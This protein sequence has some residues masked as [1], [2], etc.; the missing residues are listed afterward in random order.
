[1]DAQST[2][3]SITGDQ[4]LQRPPH[5]RDPIRTD[6]DLDSSLDVSGG[7]ADHLGIAESLGG[8]PDSRVDGIDGSKFEPVLDGSSSTSTTTT[9]RPPPWLKTNVTK[10]TTTST[11]TS[12]TT[13]TTT[14]TKPSTSSEMS[15]I[16]SVPFNHTIPSVSPPYKSQDMS[17][18][19]DTVDLEDERTLDVDDIS[20]REDLFK[21][22]N[23]LLEKELGN[24]FSQSYPKSP[25]GSGRPQ[26][27]DTQG[28][29]ILF[30]L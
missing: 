13:S 7:S 21:E 2:V 23:R 5:G 16:S 29:S 6:E 8:L 25:L 20:E 9:L 11:T 18:I 19:L 27:S 1:M 14:T 10:N 15:G 30:V 4:P 26:D 22:Q 12:S 28:E 3:S 24:G 17:S